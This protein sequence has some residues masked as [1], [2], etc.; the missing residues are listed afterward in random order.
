MAAGQGKR[1]FSKTPKVLHRILGAP[2]V[3][4][5]VE[6]ALALK[7][8]RTVVVVGHGRDAVRRAVLERYP[9]APVQFA[10]Q[11]EQRGTGDAV[12]AALS[13]LRGH[14]GPV[15]ILSG[16]VPLLDKKT[17][18]RLQRA[19]DKTGGPLAM[20]SFS[21]ADPAGY[22]RVIREAGAPVAIREHRD[23]TK[24]ERHI[25]EVNAGIYLI[26]IQFLRKA[27][28]GLTADNDQGELYLT[29]LVA[30]AA[31][32]HRVAVVEAEETLVSGVNDRADLAAMETALRHAR[33]LELM[34]SGVTLRQPET[35]YVELGVTV[36]RDVE[37]HP[38]AHLRGRTTVG[39]GAIIGAGAVITDATIH[40]GA[41]IHP[42]SVIDQSEV[43]AGAEVG[44]MARL[45]PGAVVGPRA[46]VGNWVELKNTIMGE[47]AKAN[48]LAYLGDGI[49]G[50][51]S[52]MGAGTIFC[53]YDGFL[54]HKTVMGEDVFIGSDSQM[55]APVS[56]GDGAYVASGSTITRDVPPDALAIARVKQV[57]RDGT[58]ARLKQRLKA[59]KEAKLREKAAEEKQNKK[60]KAK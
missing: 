32:T 23:C 15:L 17:V 59:K 14:K 44:P 30:M 54:K 48:H 52:N 13:A 16:D 3:A 53:N 28:K 51:R 8:E 7:C 40:D 33:N 46:K 2:L 18:N 1:M 35:V 6:L 34:R 21:P 38:G 47:G 22:G 45:R 12:Q 27:L 31:Q 36:S 49:I 58:A 50:A 26:D 41:L 43:H 24:T 37:I 60:K 39:E 25:G 19:Y 5:P 55:V 9:Q 29:D 10:V 57:N 20:L 42:Y 11:Q 56:V 4:F